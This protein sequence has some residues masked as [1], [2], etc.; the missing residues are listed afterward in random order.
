[1]E[2]SKDP[3]FLLK[4]EKLDSLTET[5]FEEFLD[6]FFGTETRPAKDEF[7]NKLSNDF[8]H[9]LLPSYHR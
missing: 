2:Y 7:I 5:M 3:L 4:P 8:S 6:K 9:Y 1:M